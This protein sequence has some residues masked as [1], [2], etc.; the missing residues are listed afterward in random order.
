MAT[1]LLQLSVALLAERWAGDPEV[2]GSSLSNLCVYQGIL[3]LFFAPPTLE[4]MQCNMQNM[5]SDQDRLQKHFAI[6]HKNNM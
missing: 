2:L 1:S 5:W 4:N 3:I 6:K